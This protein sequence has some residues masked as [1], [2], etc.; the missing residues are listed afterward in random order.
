MPTP[1]VSPHSCHTSTTL[2]LTAERERRIR[3]AGIE[4]ITQTTVVAKINRALKA[5]TTTDGA[6]LYKE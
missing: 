4:A 5:K 1:A 6:R 2:I 3:H